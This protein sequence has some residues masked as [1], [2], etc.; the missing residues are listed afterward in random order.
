[1]DVINQPEKYSTRL[2]QFSPTTKPSVYLNQS[3]QTHQNSADISNFASIN[4][5]SVHV[6]HINCRA[7]VKG[8]EL[9][10]LKALSFQKNHPKKPIPDKDFVH[11][12]SDC[13]HF[14]KTRHYAMQPLS[15]E[16]AEFPIAYSLLIYKDIEQV[17]RLLRAIYR[18]ISYIYTIKVHMKAVIQE[19]A[20]SVFFFLSS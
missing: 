3:V 15:Q 11:L 4:I 12:T 7:L 5:P 19:F 14:I 13:S 17:E 10:K 1:M 9:E 18:L 6:S 16:E 2:F 20:L 8:N